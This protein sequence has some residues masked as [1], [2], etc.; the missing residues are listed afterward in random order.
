MRGACASVPKVMR[1]TRAISTVH[2]LDVFRHTARPH[3][4]LDSGPSCRWS[5]RPVWSD[6]RP[7][8]WLT[9]NCSRP[10]T[11][12]VL[13]RSLADLVVQRV[14]I[15]L[16]ACTGD[17]VPSVPDNVAAAKLGDEHRLGLQL[18]AALRDRQKN[19]SVNPARVALARLVG[20]LLSRHLE[21]VFVRERSCCCCA[22]TSCRSKLKMRGTPLYGVHLA[23]EKS[24]NRCFGQR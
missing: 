3:S 23:V 21:A 4:M 6:S 11:P 16:K 22:V 9:T 17:L 1:R 14:T 2:R 19:A 12:D 7:P 20:E 10:E 15:K 13:A 24:G 8:I 5:L 18:H